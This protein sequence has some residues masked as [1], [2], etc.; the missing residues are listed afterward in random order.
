MTA[1]GRS[2]LIVVD[3]RI[4]NAYG[5]CAKLTRTASSNFYLAFLALPRELR[6][7][8][9]ASYAFCRLCDDIVDEPKQGVDPNAELDLVQRAL[10]GPNQTVFQD[11]PIFIALEHA[12]NRFGLDRQYFIDVIDGCRMDIRIDRYE[13]FDDL[14]EYCRRVASAV[15]IICIS[16]FGYSCPKAVKYANDLGVAFQLTNILRD[17]REDYD[18]GRVYLP[19]DE[20]REFGVSEYEFAY[21]SQSANFN[22]LMEFQI[23][24]ARSYYTSGARVLPTVTRGRQC[25]ELMNGF[26]SK[27]LDKIA[28]SE[29]DVLTQR[30]SLSSTEKLSVVLG[31]AWRSA[32]HSVNR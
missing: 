1:Q 19:Q 30:V 8:I 29:A 21:E 16:I 10:D 31:V 7:A 14:V 20:L 3:D 26:Y 17:I 9:Y 6:R 18:N 24:R 15:G 27:I 12:I 13:T 28:S 23:D 11:D 4:E 5:E 32:L 25:L 2:H 22:N